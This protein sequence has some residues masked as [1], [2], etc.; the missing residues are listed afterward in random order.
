MGIDFS[1]SPGQGRNK[2]MKR[3]RKR[4]RC[5]LL[6]AAQTEFEMT[7]TFLQNVI[8]QALNH[9]PS[10]KFWFTSLQAC[11]HKPS[12]ENLSWAYFLKHERHEED[13]DAE[14]RRE[15]RQSSK[16]LRCEQVP[17]SKI[18]II[19]VWVTQMCV[20]LCQHYNK[21]QQGVS[22]V[23]TSLHPIQKAS[24]MILWSICLMYFVYRKLTSTV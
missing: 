19:S 3:G 4:G 1:P 15:K 10:T 23:W 7:F 9:P 16:P 22:S 13:R 5:V 2:K 8:N 17:I 20:L 12:I 24:P 6:T 21:D 18:N 14:G 11:R